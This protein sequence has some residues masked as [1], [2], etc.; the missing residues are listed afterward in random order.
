MLGEDGHDR[1]AA[2]RRRARIV[3]NPPARTTWLRVAEIA[4]LVSQ[5][6][7]SRTS[8]HRRSLPMRRY[9]RDGAWSVAEFAFFAARLRSARSR[10]R[11]TYGRH[12]LTSRS[13]RITD[14][15]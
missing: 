8:P 9:L 1:A 4:A 12:G 7:A 10:W 15:K 13:V 5:S 6:A 2:L 14:E 11:V 3:H